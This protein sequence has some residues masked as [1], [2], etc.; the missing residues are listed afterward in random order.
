[1]GMINLHKCKSNILRGLQ[2]GL[3]SIGTVQFLS[4]EPRL[5]KRSLFSLNGLER[6]WIYKSQ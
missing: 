5:Y 3:H 1:M 6:V 4:N 2:I